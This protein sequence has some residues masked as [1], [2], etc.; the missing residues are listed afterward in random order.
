MVRQLNT[1]KEDLLNAVLVGL[2]LILSNA[3]NPLAN[4]NYLG[5]TAGSYTDITIYTTLL[6]AM[7]A[8]LLACLLQF[9]C[10]Y[11]LAELRHY[12]HLNFS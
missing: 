2:S 8:A 4:I 7:Y 12:L 5:F 3:F 10:N 6:L 1:I 11:N 9:I